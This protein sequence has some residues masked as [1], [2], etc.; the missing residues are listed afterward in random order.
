M[1]ALQAERHAALIAYRDAVPRES[2]ARSAGDVIHMHANR[3]LAV[4]PGR[5]R[6]VRTLASDLLH[7]P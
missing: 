3:M 1:A 5:E 6:V 2:A 4:D 7:R